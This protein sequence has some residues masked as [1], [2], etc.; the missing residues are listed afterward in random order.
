[1]PDCNR[2]LLPAVRRIPRT[3]LLVGPEP[4]PL[5]SATPGT[6]HAAPQPPDGAS[7]DGDGHRRPRGAR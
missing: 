3:G 5:G 1:M 6:R 4:A 2:H 7:R